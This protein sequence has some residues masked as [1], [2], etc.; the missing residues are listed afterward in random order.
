MAE[1]DRFWCEGKSSHLDALKEAEAEEMAALRVRLSVASPEEEAGI[2]L[3]MERV[4]ESY[5]VQRQAVDASL[6]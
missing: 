5:R 2:K 3:E 6:Y 1:E 4:R